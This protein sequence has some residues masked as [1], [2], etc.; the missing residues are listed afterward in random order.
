MSAVLDACRLAVDFGTSNTVALLSLPGRNPTLLLFDG[1]PLL[2]SAVCATN[3]GELLVGADAV[4]A[5]PMYPQGY[6]PHPKRHI[7]D[8]VLLLD[9]VEVD[10]ARVI[11]TVLGRVVEEAARVAGGRPGEVVLTHPASW[12]QRRKE[13]LL[14]AAAHAAIIGVRLMPEPVAAGRYF[15]DVL[16]QRLPAG[17]YLLVYDLGAGTFDTSVLRRTGDVFEVAASHGLADAGGL[18]IDAAVMTHILATTLADDQPVRDRLT[19]PRTATDRRHSLQLWA[20]VRTAKESLSRTASALVHVP[21]VDRDV[22]L[23]REQ[24]DLLARPVLDRTIEATRAVLTDARVPPAGLAAIVLTGGASRMPLVAT[25]LHQAFGIAPTVIEQP[26]L[27]VVEGSLGGA[28]TPV[29]ADGRP[30]ETGPPAHVLAEA[31][32]RPRRWRT[33]RTLIAAVAILLAL[34]TGALVT[35]DDRDG[36]SPFGPADGGG[37]TGDRAGEAAGLTNGEARGDGRRTSPIPGAPVGSGGAG[38]SQPGVGVSS[39]GAL[40]GAPPGATATTGPTT[41]P[42]AQP[43]PSPS[44]AS[45]TTSSGSGYACEQMGLRVSRVSG[46]AVTSWPDVR[47][48]GC[49]RAGGAQYSAFGEA[50]IEVRTSGTSASFSYRVEL[51]EC[52]GNQADSKVVSTGSTS[53]MSTTST[54]STNTWWYAA[55]AKVVVRPTTVDFQAGGTRWL[56]TV[57]TVTS[58][59]IQLV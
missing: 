35:L 41:A 3:P 10:I 8:R 59:C 50:T 22:P 45:R 37:R 36:W 7:D 54:T 44:A 18:D 47:L 30:V 15:V 53:A 43:P 9:R 26:Q 33:R 31:L 2:P 12:G 27:V 57:D 38:E 21:L 16:H 46:A 56:A 39:P 28:G 11:G 34:L 1:N 42:A 32:P 14:A 20:G 49:V 6:E 29:R 58:P 17:G 55:S 25:L 48:R 52:N 5:A 23:G 51:D 24:L 4:N 40:P 19:E 13:V